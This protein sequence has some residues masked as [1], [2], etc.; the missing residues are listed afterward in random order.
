MTEGVA[1]MAIVIGAATPPPS[2][3]PL[4][5]GPG[6]SP[7]GTGL[8]GLDVVR[9]IA[10]ALLTWGLVACVVGIAVSVIVWV[11]SQQHS[12]YS[13]TAAGKVGVLV[14]MGGA[15]LLGGANSIVAFFAAL[16]AQIR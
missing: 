1:G 9:E 3:V 14:S 5:P 7:N 4:P 6:V 12:N 10:G 11:I 2:P 16:G 13:G 15:V 8:P